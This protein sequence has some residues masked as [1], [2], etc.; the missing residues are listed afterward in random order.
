M[1]SLHQPGTEP[2]RERPARAG[3]QHPARHLASRGAAAHTS[4]AKPQMRRRA[5]GLPAA[6]RLRRFGVAVML[7]APLFAGTATLSAKLS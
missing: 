7:A 1:Q 6:G 3:Q 2:N 4:P 5:R